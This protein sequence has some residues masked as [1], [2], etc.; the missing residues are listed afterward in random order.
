[1]HC[2]VG[3]HCPLHFYSC[4]L[5]RQLV[6]LSVLQFA[7]YTATM[8]IPHTGS[9]R[10]KASKT[11]RCGAAGGWA[12]SSIGFQRPVNGPS[13][14]VSQG[15]YKKNANQQRFHQKMQTSMQ[16]SSDTTR[17]WKKN[18]KKMQR[19]T[20]AKIQ[21]KCKENATEMQNCSKFQENLFFGGL[22]FAFFCMFCMFLHFLH[23]F[24][25]FLHFFCFFLPWHCGLHLFLHFCRDFPW[26]ASWEGPRR[27]VATLS[28]PPCHR[29][30]FW[31]V[32]GG[33]DRSDRAPRTTRSRE[34]Q[35]GGKR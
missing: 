8:H 17:K 31:R 22:F 5:S 20:H 12:A 23:F 11:F 34:I 9:Y 1:M 21:K 13:Q 26:E 24:C 18:A 25:I 35:S 14:G 4:I 32:V 2:Q 6:C 28:I 33:T 16:S 30:R 3:F 7:P 19:I 10:P 15:K 29:S 27:S